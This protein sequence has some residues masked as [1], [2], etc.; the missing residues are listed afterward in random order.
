MG[1]ENPSVA[2]SRQ[3]AA[4]FPDFQTATLGRASAAMPACKT[5][6]LD[7]LEDDEYKPISQPD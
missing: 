1:C 3:N 2:A 7:K 5:N 4:N 6:A